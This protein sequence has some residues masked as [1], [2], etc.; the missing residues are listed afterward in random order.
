MVAR[1]F[2]LGFLLFCVGCEAPSGP[3]AVGSKVKFKTGNTEYVVSRYG[4]DIAG[5]YILV[6]YGEGWTGTIRQ[7]KY[8]LLELVKE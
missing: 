2:F 1:I 6:T 5:D 7:N 3:F 8:E 4:S